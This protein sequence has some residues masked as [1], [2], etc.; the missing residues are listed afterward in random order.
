MFWF[1]S[2]WG[3][4]P[5]AIR[6]GIEEGLPSDEVYDAYED[7]YGN[8]W[9][10]TDHG[11]SR[12]DGYGFDN[13]TVADGL[14]DNTVFGF[15][16]DPQGRVWLRTLDGSLTCMDHGRLHPYL[17]ND[18]L[19]KLL[20]GQFIETLYFDNRHRMYFVT[21]AE[22][23]STRVLDLPSGELV[24]QDWP[25]GNWGGLYADGGGGEVIPI[26]SFDKTA[27][28]QGEGIE[29][30]KLQDGTLSRWHLPAPS[31]Y[32]FTGRNILLSMGKGRYVGI[33]S[34]RLY[35]IRDGRIIHN[36]QLPTTMSGLSRDRGGNLWLTGH[37]GM[38]LLSDSLTMLRSYFDRET[39][40]KVLEDRNGS[41]WVT[42]SHGVMQVRDVR[43]RLYAVANGQ[44]LR[45]ARR[46]R[47]VDDRLYALYDDC[48]IHWGTIHNTT[49]EWETSESEIRFP[50][51]SLH[52]FCLLP[53]GSAILSIGGLYDLH[54][55]SIVR[56]PTWLRAI[57]TP[58][59]YRISGKHL[60][61][62]TNQGA[63][64]FDATGQEAGVRLDST[65]FFGTAML[66]DLAGNIWVG[67]NTGV[68]V[69][70]PGHGNWR[71]SPD[72][73]MKFRV[74]DLALLEDGTVVVATRGWGLLF[75]RGTAVQWLRVSDG[76]PS[77]MCD[78]LYVGA[79]GLWVCSDKGLSLIPNGDLRPE[80]LPDC[81]PYHIGLLEG[82]PTRQVN[83]VVEHEGYLYVATD[84][85]LVAMEAPRQAPAALIPQVAISGLRA[86]H[87]WV[88][89]RGSLRPD[90]DN[91]EF[92][93]QVGAT[94]GSQ[95]LRYRYCLTGYDR[96]WRVTRERSVNYYELPPGS[97]TFRVAAF[98]AD[99]PEGALE[100]S[101]QVYLPYKYHET[102]WFR[103]A[104]MA[105]ILLGLVLGGWWI[106]R[107]RHRRVQ[108][109]LLRLQAEVK[110]L[111]SQM[112]P[113]FMFNALTSIQHL[114][115]TNDTE[116][117]QRHL[118]GFA[119][120]MRGILDAIRQET[121]PISQEVSLLTGYM[122]LER[123][124]LGEGFAFEVE[125][126]PGHD[127]SRLS[128]PP[129][130]VQPLVENAIWHGLQLR[131]ENPTV[132][133]RF[134]WSAPGM[135]CCEVEDNGIGRAAASKIVRKHLG[136]SVALENIGSRITLINATKK[137][138]I[139]MEILDLT[140]P[141]GTA[142]GTL[143]KLLIPAERHGANEI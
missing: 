98:Y 81:R 65:A 114:I 96:E 44:S 66:E 16:E 67:T 133:L 41:Y 117:A 87:R 138:P 120:L 92:H 9:F 29:V 107:S 7:P 132:W 88:T 25:A 37:H 19:L 111:R 113:H 85:G 141:D 124:R 119:R 139:H 109:N 13:F 54:R 125:L 39:V 69:Y 108:N 103:V 4:D 36:A 82:M 64:V 50:N 11:L 24:R 84:R 105:L 31:P 115:L 32:W 14:S 126:E 61:I 93:F 100:V 94:P 102:L 34:G 60:C 40:F 129:M 30:C 90:E 38:V 63:W 95:D 15:V 91:L 89:D 86:G 74:T 27:I 53:D 77:D 22:G 3:Q 59:Q 26:V 10:A 6:Y 127:W 28:G 99:R 68:R 33:Y 118:V 137:I 8:I 23:S 143:V 80:R 47:L 106:L 52:D 58:W 43:N 12:F 142:G 45:G 110:A 18:K 78:R 122:E 131:K 135:I 17:H 73:G 75:V 46:L 57:G 20:D 1:W 104:A 97:Y 140:R 134:G 116:T 55:G 35:E 71:P 130:L 2:A 101:Q 121:I 56:P 48:A 79:S 21:F 51:K 5:V 136:P 62:S 70:D 76:L 112:Q 83:D 123:L 42:T 128:I 49:I 72:Y